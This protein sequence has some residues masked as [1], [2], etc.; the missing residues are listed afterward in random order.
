MQLPVTNFDAWV[1]QL[2]DSFF[3][4]N[5][6]YYKTFAQQNP[7]D[8]LELPFK[9]INL[10]CVHYGG[11]YIVTVDEET[12]KEGENENYFFHFI[13]PGHDEK[14]IQVMQ[15]DQY[16]IIK[17]KDIKEEI[18]NKGN[19]LSNYKYYKKVSLTHPNFEVTSAVFS[20]GILSVKLIDKTKEKEKI[21]TKMI[22]VTT[23]KE[24]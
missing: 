14:T 5:N 2:T 21:N 23:L 18:L 10:P 15:K 22:E 1:D 12:M 4:H 17:S 24:S 9:G 16:L 20:K 8:L 11:D 3:N 6:K 19:P 7:R 13:L